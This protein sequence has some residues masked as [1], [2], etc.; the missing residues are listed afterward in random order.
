MSATF[1]PAASCHRCGTA[2]DS[3]NDSAAH[4][5][6]NALGGRL[7]P[8]G[9]ICRDCNT[10]LSHLVDT[11]LVRA[12][13]P[14]PTLLNVPRQRGEHPPVMLETRAGYKV[15][16]YPDG[17][18]IR[19]DPLYDKTVT[20]QGTQLEIG[21]SNP[22]M[23]GQLLDRAAK[24][25]PQFD[26]EEAKKY[27]QVV[28]L[29][30]S[31]MRT[32][33]NFAPEATFGAVAVCLWLFMTHRLGHAPM[34]REGLETTIENFRRGRGTRMRYFV[35][36]LPGLQGPQVDLG[37]KIVFRTI[38]A[39]GE[40][41][42]YVEILNAFRV[43]GVFA[44]GPASNGPPVEEMY[45]YDLL[46]RRE[47]SQEFSIDSAEFE[48]QDWDRVG[49]GATQADLAQLLSAHESAVRGLA[50]LY[51]GLGASAGSPTP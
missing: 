14:W 39:S 4:I 35:D 2:L 48:R 42:T 16:V 24:E 43:G 27:A 49:L 38:P 41:V 7:A 29:P 25:F 44:Q 37:H 11:E 47:R 15:L 23:L 51:A 8:R 1:T 5:I 21:A 12:F 3:S 10:A 30:L 34:M 17:T 13:G 22:K 19:L 6:P 40:L 33:V 31:E 50:A 45:A 46:T 32:R 20:Q 28:K 18:L 26:P 36:G 9:I